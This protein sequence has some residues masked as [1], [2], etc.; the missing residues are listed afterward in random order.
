MKITIL[1]VDVGIYRKYF[2]INGEETS[3]PSDQCGR[4]EGAF[5]QRE[6]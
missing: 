4:S 5:E 2:M 1:A 3:S 6:N